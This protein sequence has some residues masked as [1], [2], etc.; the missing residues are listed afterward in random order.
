MLKKTIKYTDFNDVEREEDFYFNISKA[1][2]AEMQFGHKGGLSNY[3]QKIVDSEDDPE[4]MAMFTEII[5]KAYGEKS[6][7]G[8]RFIKSAEKAE[9]FRQTNAYG[10]LLME[11]MSDDGA[12]AAFVNAIVPSF[13]EPKK[14]Q[15]KPELP[16]KE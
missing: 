7:D 13:D 14:D 10:E 12:A 15:D 8:K 11:L 16:V 1:E 2:L 4:I 6:E 5:L 3:I 9:E